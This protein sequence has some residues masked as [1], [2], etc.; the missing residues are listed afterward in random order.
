M[1]IKG[2]PSRLAP[3]L[4]VIPYFGL[5]GIT[6]GVSLVPVKQTLATAELQESVTR[7]VCCGCRKVPCDSLKYDKR[8][9]LTVVEFIVQLCVRLTCWERKALLLPNPCSRFGVAAWK[10]VNG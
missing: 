5:D 1:L 8:S 2:R 9:S 6:L 7:L 10:R 3:R 4:G